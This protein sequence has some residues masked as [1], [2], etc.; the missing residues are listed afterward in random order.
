MGHFLSVPKNNSLE[1][2]VDKWYDTDVSG[3]HLD[4]ELNMMHVSAES[5]EVAGVKTNK[6]IWGII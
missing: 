1:L 2:Y 5:L 3:K 6:L 4:R